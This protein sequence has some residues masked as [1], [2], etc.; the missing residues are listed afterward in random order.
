[1]KPIEDIF[2]APMPGGEV[3]SVDFSEKLQL[4]LK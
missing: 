1:M 3:G 4:K 2:D